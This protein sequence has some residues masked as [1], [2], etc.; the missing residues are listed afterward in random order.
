MDH[1]QVKNPKLMAVVLMLGAFVGLFGETALN[2]ALTEIMDNFGVGPATAQWLTTGYLLTL[3]ILVPVSGLLVR[4]FT[5]RT[6]VVAGLGL[7]LIGAVLAAVITKFCSSFT[8]SCRSSN[9]YRYS[10]TGY[11]KRRFINFPN[12]KTRSCD[13]NRWI[14]YY[15]RSCT[16]TNSFRINY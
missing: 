1:I 10:F 9:R 2:M 8:W 6:L 11:V 4:W 15:S 7:S 3:A 13:G 14:S 16:W 5:T 12:S